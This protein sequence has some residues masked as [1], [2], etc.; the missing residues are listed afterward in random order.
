MESA[1]AI[2]PAPRHI[3]RRLALSGLAGLFWGCHI[4][5]MTQPRTIKK[6]RWGKIQLTTAIPTGDG[7][8][9]R[10]QHSQLLSHLQPDWGK[11]GPAWMRIPARCIAR[12]KVW[13]M[14]SRTL[15]GQFWL[16]FAKWSGGTSES[17]LQKG[18]SLEIIIRDSEIGKM[19]SSFWSLVWEHLSLSGMPWP[20]ATTCYVYGTRGHKHW[21]Y[22]RIMEDASRNPHQSRSN[23]L[24][25]SWELRNISD[26]TRHSTACVVCIVTFH[27]IP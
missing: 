16:D 27:N 26:I 1:A 11:C 3:P 15:P 20:R 6:G 5:P 12:Q 24:C 22:P 23:D 17:R 19:C 2:S 21:K 8:M 7:S 25:R 18:L 10:M 4:L 9:M 13:F 14:W